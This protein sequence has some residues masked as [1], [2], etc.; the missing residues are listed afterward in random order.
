MKIRR[1]SRLLTSMLAAGIASLAVCEAAYASPPIGSGKLEVKFDGPIPTTTVQAGPGE[2]VAIRKWD[3]VA[4]ELGAQTQPPGRRVTN[5]SAATEVN[6]PEVA[7]TVNKD[8]KI[9]NRTVTRLD[10]RPADGVTGRMPL[11]WAVDVNTISMAWWTPNAA[12]TWTVRV[13][14]KVVAKTTKTSWTGIFPDRG[15]TAS[16]WTA[17]SR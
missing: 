2:V 11:Q 10:G 16:R 17:L 14:G 9:I 5:T 12:M 13:D 15:T 8:G 6:A 7:Y 3:P 4:L 1:R